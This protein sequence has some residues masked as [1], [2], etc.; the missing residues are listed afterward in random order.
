MKP[1]SKLFLYASFGLAILVMGCAETKTGATGQPGSG[2][3]STVSPA[4]APSPTS[5]GKVS[6][7]TTSSP[8]VSQGGDDDTLKACLARI[9]DD[10]SDGQRML[11]TLTCE[12]D[13]KV[14]NPIEI[15]P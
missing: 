2:A 14:R 8:L 11:A 1:F 12:R 9:P 10:A 13:E 4:S 6:A 3:T 15:V 5:S 7:E